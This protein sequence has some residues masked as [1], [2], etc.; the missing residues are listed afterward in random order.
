MSQVTLTAKQ[1]SKVQAFVAA[2]REAK[3]N[4]KLTGEAKHDYAAI[5]TVANR[6][7]QATWLAKGAKGTYYPWMCV[8]S[9]AHEA[10]AEAVGKQA[11]RQSAKPTATVAASGTVARYDD[12]KGKG[13]QAR[14]ARR[15][16]ANGGVDPLAPTT[17]TAK[18]MS[19][20]KLTVDALASRV[21]ALDAKLDII[22]AKL[23]S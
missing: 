1:D 16:N 5:L 19:S 21:D 9:F 6:Q 22:L 20:G 12:G 2:A 10:I 23:A 13:W 4:G 14:S 17:T 3:S 7:K 18:P 11:V 8:P 15:A